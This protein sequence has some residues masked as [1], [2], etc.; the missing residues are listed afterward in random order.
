MYNNILNFENLEIGDTVTYNGNVIVR[1]NVWEDLYNRITIGK[2]YIVKD[3]FIQN[4]EKY[5]TVRTDK[6][7]NIYYPIEVFS[8][9]PKYIMFKKYGLR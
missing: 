5:I 9:S 6:Y 1:E 4:G 8:S 7:T 2:E 3:R